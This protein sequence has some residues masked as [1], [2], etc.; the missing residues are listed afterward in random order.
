MNMMEHEPAGLQALA[1]QL[2]FEHRAAAELRV[3]AQRGQLERD[4]I[5]AVRQLAELLKQ[6]ANHLIID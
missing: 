4:R 6:R 3:A 1:R 5:G 2:H